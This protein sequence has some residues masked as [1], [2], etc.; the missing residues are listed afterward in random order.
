M[1]GRPAARLEF[2]DREVRNGSQPFAFTY[3]GL[4]RSASQTVAQ[5]LEFEDQFDIL[6]K[7]GEFGAVSGNFLAKLIYHLERSRVSRHMG[8][9]CEYL[10]ELRTLSVRWAN[11]KR[12][13]CSC[14]FMDHV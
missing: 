2:F 4:L 12:K 5:V 8:D 11:I 3:S 6:A 10:R 14:C 9:R 7:Y 13:Q 1:A